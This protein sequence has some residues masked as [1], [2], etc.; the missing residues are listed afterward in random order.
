V[1]LADSFRPAV[2]LVLAFRS[3]KTEVDGFVVKSLSEV[4]VI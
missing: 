1:L 3:I 4:Y 2:Y